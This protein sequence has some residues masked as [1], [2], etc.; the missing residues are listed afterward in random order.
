MIKLNLVIGLLFLFLSKGISASVV[1]SLEIE[2]RKQK[3][4]KRVD[5]L[6]ELAWHYRLTN[7]KEALE[8]AN[9]A[10]E[11]SRELNYLIGEG[12]ALRRLGVLRLQ[13]HENKL[14]LKHLFDALAIYESIPDWEELSKTHLSIGN[15]Y[16]DLKNFEKAQSHYLKAEKIC[17][18]HGFTDQ[19]TVIANNIGATQENF[20]L[21][22]EAL[23]TYKRA[24]VHSDSTSQNYSNLLLNASSAFF[25]TDQLDSAI[26]YI[27]RAKERYAS[28]NDTNGLVKCWQNEAV[29]NES[30]E[31]YGVAI[32]KYRQALIY[33]EAIDNYGAQFDCEQGLMLCFGALGEIDSMYVHFENSLDLGELLVDSKTDKALHEL[34]VKY[35]VAKKE[36]DLKKLQQEREFEAER[37]S[38]KQK[39]I[40]YL[41]AI[42]AIIAVLLILLFLYFRQKQNSANLKVKITNNEI[43]SL[44]KNQELQM[45]QALI[46]G[47]DSERKR[48]SQDLHDRIGG[49]LATINLQFEGAELDEGK[50]IENVRNLVNESIKEVRSISH[51]LSDGRI[52]QVGLVS[53]IQGLKQSLTDSGKIKVDLFAE[54]YN[55]N[56]TIESEREVYKIILELIGNTLKHADASSIVIQLNA[57]NENVQLMFEDNGKGFD[58][59]ASRNGL[60]MRTIQQR[61]SNLNGDLRIDSKKGYGT[62]VIIE[63]PIE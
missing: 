37:N 21:Y 12:K 27:E 7:S 4:T 2:L 40:N 60:G 31:R 41:L 63:I 24:L 36:S 34:S 20:E 51:N 44:I 32:E 9:L 58:I 17:I 30:E 11:E 19:Y 62:T 57:F 50:R 47:Q 52:D 3:D 49:L 53:A 16:M 6:N 23:D 26:I 5:V 42:I 25:Y 29:Y 15:A 33:A 35:E 46:E 14:A 18:A 8:F 39:T 38:L 45:Y 1:D 28:A 54:N 56:L 55:K 61:V 48:I 59:N 13:S 43:E 10:L 22:D